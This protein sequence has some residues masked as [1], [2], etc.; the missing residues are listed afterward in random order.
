MSDGTKEWKY[1]IESL[2]EASQNMGMGF[3]F[4]MDM[5]GRLEDYGAHNNFVSSIEEGTQ[6][7]FNLSTDLVKEQAKLAEMETT[8]QYTTI[9]ENG[10]EQKTLAN[11]TAIDAQREKVQGL[12]NDIAETQQAMQ[13]LV[14]HTA[15]DYN[16]Q[17]E[18]A[19][20]A[21]TT[22]TE[23]RQRILNSNEYGDNTQQ[24]ADLMEAQ[25]QKWA[26]DNHIELDADLNIVDSGS[27]IAALQE[28]LKGFQELREIG[29]IDLNFDSAKMSAT[30]LKT[31]IDELS[32]ERV[33]IEATASPEALSTMDELID[34]C[35]KEYY[36]KLNA[37]TGGGFDQAISIIE[38]IQQE[39]ANAQEE[40]PVISVKAIVE[41]NRQIQTLAGQLAELP[42]E[43]QTT[44]GIDDSNVGD[45]EGILTQL[46][47]SP[48]SI[49][50]PVNYTDGNGTDSLKIEAKDATVKVVPDPEEVEVT[51][52]D[53]T[54]KVTPEPDTVEVTVIAEAS[55]KQEVDDLNASTSSLKGKTVEA[56][57]EVSG[58]PETN[59]LK[60]AI[61]SLYPRTVQEKANVLGTSEVQALVDTIASVHSKTVTITT[62]YVQNGN[63]SSDSIIKR[64]T[65]TPMTV[66][67]ANGTP[68]IKSTKFNDGYIGKAYA[69]GTWGE[70]KDTNA[71]TGELGEELIVRDN[72]FFTVGSNGP[73]MVHLKKND[74]VFNHR[75][76]KDILT[77]GYTTGRGKALADGNARGSGSGGITFQ[78]G[79]ASGKANTSNTLNKAAS[80]LS[81]AA[82]STTKASDALADLIKKISDNVK[83][84][85]EVLIS[86]TE[87][88]IEYY[89]A[90]SE[91]RASIKNK[92][93]NI[94]KAENL[95][96]KEIKYYQKA[97]KEYTSYAN[98]VAS[99]VGLSASLKKK[100]Q[101]G[102]I[103]IQ[104]LSEDDLSRVE[105]YQKWYD[106]I[107]EC[108]NA[109]QDL[110]KEQKELAA[111]KLTNI[112]EVYDS[113]TNR[114]K[115]NQDLISAKL[116]YRE[117]RGMSI[118][119][120]SGYYPL[121]DKQISYEKNNIAMLKK[122]AAEYEKQLKAYGKAY[123]TN[124]KEYR[125]MQ[126]TLIG[127]N[128]E[129]Y[130]SMA[131]LEDWE[132]QV[133]DAK[134]QLKQWAVDIADRASEKQSAAINY[135]DTADAYTVTEKDYTEQIKTN[136]RKI[137]ALYKLR[138][139][140]AKNMELYAYNSEA[141]QE[142][143]DAIAQ[144]DVEIM[145]IATDSE[146]L[147]NTVMSLR[148]EPFYEAQEA[149]DGVVDEYD[150]LRGLMDSD[151]FI[152]DSDASFTENG[153]TNLLLLQ[154]SIDATKTKMANYRTQIENLNEQYENGC[155]SQEEY[156]EKLKE[157]HDGLLD[158]ATAM[159]N[160][161]QEM[162]DM[163]EA[164]LEKKNEL[165]HEDID[166]YK[167][168]LEA[169]KKYH[170]YDKKLK[171]QTKEINIL[172]AQAAA[173]EGV[174]DAASK[175]RL[176]QIKAQIAEAEEDLEDTKYEHSYELKSDGYDKLADDVDK[177]L[178]R[179]LDSLRTSTDMQ[180][181]VIDGM[182]SNVTTS[183]E[184]TFDNLNKI[185]EEHGLV[186]SDTFSNTIG[187]LNAEIQKL[188]ESAG[189]IRDEISTIYNTGSVQETKAD[190]AVQNSN[191]NGVTTTSSAT[192][193][194][195]KDTVD[196]SDDATGAV[197]GA[198]TGIKYVR[199]T[200]A[201]M[202]KS[203]I[204]L[205]V[206]KTYKLKA[207]VEPSDAAENFEWS[208]G[209]TKVAKV[210]DSGVVTAVAVGTT[211]V[212]ATEHRSNKVATCKVT[213]KATP[214]K[215]DKQPAKQPS[216]T[217]QNKNTTG[218][219]KTDIFSG[220]AKDA[221]MKGNSKLNK[222]V[223]IVDRLA[224]LGYAS[225]K[226]ARTQLWKNLKGSGTYSG[227]AAQNTWLIKQLKQ[228]GYSD[229]GF[230]DKYI[231]FDVDEFLDELRGKSGTKKIKEQI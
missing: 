62:N 153:L 15:E 42:P 10:N 32:Q 17:V 9:D 149:L 154:E 49:N 167:Q 136:N 227:T 103:D 72:K 176:A 91:N 218:S 217:V 201:K 68:A 150:A 189:S 129:L 51:A 80:N 158:S 116:D 191:N 40:Q 135:K 208:S 26:E 8:G 168:A 156:A 69:K 198:G 97:L 219:A 109:I 197:T 27:Q 117:A 142:Y 147:K 96:G 206:G 199:A 143:A 196:K 92:N 144:I 131:A 166:A 192:D 214:K 160:Y 11:Q 127:I 223:S 100:V 78:G 71:L 58:E 182:L 36:V 54:V 162:L 141:Y 47:N 212:K 172:K 164:Q 101:N 157:L 165:M 126:S 161:E 33:N 207:I 52:K 112:T 75:Q 30:D 181:Q 39:I 55:G 81:S 83:D 102:T 211:T 200:S 82:Q 169:K 204:T 50:I 63:P 56:K 230:V 93:A 220:I 190:N 179:T 66:S 57:A 104:Q 77:K 195:V 67:R 184:S 138:E 171:N 14:A 122:E 115:A 174:S 159:A 19:K 186:M 110:I 178:D 226:A 180:S 46:A 41:G 59:N 163:Y 119:E 89:Q 43:V 90:V 134:E 130:E 188:A 183:C 94:T 137:S 133:R 37:E 21:I 85:I 146:E 24:I 3:E 98:N 74:I 45:I 231:Q 107:I 106:K 38:Q 99:Q 113:Y 175:A 148:W 114:T 4:F 34:K 76:T 203:S 13:Q 18:S 25:I 73:E 111:Q 48:E 2:E 31:K 7:L 29:N 84:W 151:T 95:T 225:N 173:L 132:K 60:A 64:E 65:G 187:T 221:S 185:V 70:P 44:I 125:E 229:G 121:M 120:S 216:A 12:K 124:T 194:I 79:A 222:E 152:S 209:N 86:R 28:E 140:K 6:K 170:D 205:N 177:A 210:S 22:L 128:Q 20:T 118:H 53:T 105:A 61:D 224:Y 87:S 5:F 23:E 228:V 215:S 155:W 123:G 1:N 16:S 193:Q 139:E 213:V 202:D 108:R 35:N 145:N 88:K